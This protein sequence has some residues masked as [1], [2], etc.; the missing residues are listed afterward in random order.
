LAGHGGN[1]DRA[2]SVELDLVQGRTQF[3]SFVFLEKEACV[4]SVDFD[5]RCCIAL[6]FHEANSGGTSINLSNAERRERCRAKERE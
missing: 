1:A 2:F 6:M 4:E 3:P 5:C